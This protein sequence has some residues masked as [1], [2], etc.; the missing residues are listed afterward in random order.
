MPNLDHYSDG[1]DPEYKTNETEREK[2]TLGDTWKT[3]AV[4]NQKIAIYFKQC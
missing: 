4:P 1:N 3:I 2:P